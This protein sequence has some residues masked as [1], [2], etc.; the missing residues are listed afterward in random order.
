MRA[1]GGPTDDAALVRAMADAITDVPAPRMKPVLKRLPVK[2]AL[3]T[4]AVL[5][6]AT[7]A[8]AAT[9]DLPDAA[10]D[11]L[12]NAASHIGVNLPDSAS[13]QARESTSEVGPPAGVGP[14]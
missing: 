6:T 8:A 7:G 3:A 5:V 12:A 10:Q 9:G 4:A 1:R 13:E 2:V 11:G 14:A